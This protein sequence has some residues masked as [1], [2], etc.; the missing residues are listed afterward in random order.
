M[1]SLVQDPT[2]AALAH[3]LVGDPVGLLSMG[4]DL[5]SGLRPLTSGH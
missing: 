5:V 2:F 4:V 3:H 1:L